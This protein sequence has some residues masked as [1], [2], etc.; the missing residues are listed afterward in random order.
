MR[1]AGEDNQFNTSDDA[2]SD[3]ALVSGGG[4]ATIKWTAGKAG[5]INY[6][7]DFH[8]TD[9]KGTIEVK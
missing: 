4:T 6:Q 5:T 3:P 2:V 9:M 8:P 7:C 1:I